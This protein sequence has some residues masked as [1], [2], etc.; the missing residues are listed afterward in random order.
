[1]PRPLRESE[2]PWVK[3]LQGWWISDGKKRFGT[4]K[5][6]AE[7]LAVTVSTLS[8]YM[9]GDRFPNPAQRQWLYQATSLECFR[10]TVI[11]KH[12]PLKGTSKGSTTAPHAAALNAW[13]QSQR[14]YSSKRELAAVLGFTSSKL[15]NYFASRQFPDPK[16]RSRLYE[17]TK[18]D[19]FGPGAESALAL[20]RR[21]LRVKKP[22]V[23]DLLV[24][25]HRFIDRIYPNTHERRRFYG[26][27]S[28]FIKEIERSEIA[29]LSE[30][31]HR[32]LIRF[33]LE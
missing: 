33:E 3:A 8:R 7:A 11:T 20:H 30:I 13:F 27:E 19:C 16:Q 25:I 14:Q 4:S 32:K 23:R 21:L 10:E 28:K 17:V 6:L 26:Y 5:K 1:M 18:L 31:D 22:W 9:S 24:E 12:H 29:Q 15:L 2:V